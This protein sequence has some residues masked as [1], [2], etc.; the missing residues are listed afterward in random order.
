MQ[1][2]SS[3]APCSFRPCLAAQTKDVVR[4]PANES[5]KANQ[6]AL[7]FVCT[8]CTC[9]C[10]CVYK[11]CMCAPSRVITGHAGFLN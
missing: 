7:L 4:I 8:V 3:E 5:W 11:V 9:I 6:E 1:G 2:A 10:V